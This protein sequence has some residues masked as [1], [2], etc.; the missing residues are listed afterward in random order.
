MCVFAHTE[1][2][3]SRLPAWE[4]RTLSRSFAPEVTGLQLDVPLLLMQFARR[5][6]FLE[7]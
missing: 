1:A 5:Q 2:V 7:R 6:I 4:I 3:S